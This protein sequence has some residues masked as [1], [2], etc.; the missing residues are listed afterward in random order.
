M[1]STLPDTAHHVNG[2]PT[3]L[4]LAA[5]VVAVTWYLLDKRRERM[6]QQQITKRATRTT[7]KNT[8]LRTP[9]GRRLP[10]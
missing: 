7:D 1:A 5:V 10:Y 3:M 9:G 4:W 6:K 8:D 2:L